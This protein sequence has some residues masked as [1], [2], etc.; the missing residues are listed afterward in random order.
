[1][2]PNYMQAVISEAVDLVV[3][4]EPAGRGQP[5]RDVSRYISSRSGSTAQSYLSL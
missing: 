2:A 1:M 5:V 3:S 4:I